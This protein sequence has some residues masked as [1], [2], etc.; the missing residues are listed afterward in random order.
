MGCRAG[1]WLSALSPE[2][3]VGR[4][5]V[6][7][8]PGSTCLAPRAAASLD[9]HAH[10]SWLLLRGA[11]NLPVLTLVKATATGL[12]GCPLHDLLFYIR[13]DPLSK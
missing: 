5:G 9:L 10:P 7:G 13:K 12:R 8:F 3:S 6:G 4:A 11:Q 2:A 1:C